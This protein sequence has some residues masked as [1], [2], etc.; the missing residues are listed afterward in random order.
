MQNL[1]SRQSIRTTSAGLNSA[2]NNRQS[3]STM[4]SQSP[5]KFNGSL[6]SAEFVK[7][8][9]QNELNLILKEHE[10]MNSLTK[11]KMNTPSKKSMADPERWRNKFRFLFQRERVLSFASDDTNKALIFNK[12]GLASTLE[13]KI[14]RPV[15]GAWLL[16][17]CAVFWILF[18]EFNRQKIEMDID[19]KERVRRQIVDAFWNSPGDDESCLSHN[20]VEDRG[21]PQQSQDNQ[22]EILAM[23]RRLESQRM[24]KLYLDRLLYLP[25][26]GSGSEDKD[27]EV[28][29]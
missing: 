29:D 21:R 23:G 9:I 19:A 26:V 13:P 12:R 27:K 25:E 18:A 14:L 3:L 2:A 20:G 10:R 16:H 6:K 1:M 17:H 28:L 8:R 4:K 15:L 5:A 22:E 11:S 7:S 24:L